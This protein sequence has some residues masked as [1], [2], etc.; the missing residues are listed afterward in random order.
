[1]LL[2][3]VF[4]FVRKSDPFEMGHFGGIFELVWVTQWLWENTRRTRSG[5]SLV[6]H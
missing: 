3:T 4:F 1:M 5:S 2:E 6:N